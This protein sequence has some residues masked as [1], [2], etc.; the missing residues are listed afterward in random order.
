[1]FKEKDLPKLQ[2]LKVKDSKLH[3]PKQ[4]EKLFADIIAIAASYK[5]IKIE[6]E[7]IDSALK[8]VD[9]NLNFLEAINMAKII[10]FLNPDK[11]YI[12]C[13]SPNIK[14]FE[15]YLKIYLIHKPELILAHHA[16]RDFPIV[17]AASILSK[18]TRDKEIKELLKKYGNIGS[19]YPADPITQ[20][21]LKENWNKHPEIFRKTWITYKNHEKSKLQKNLKDF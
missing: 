10:N 4:R 2:A 11:V 20:K 13:P 17:S 19:G 21:F 7:E 5:I 18:Y 14:S 15:N 6:P 1:M 8:S 12:D 16:D 9:L 3:T